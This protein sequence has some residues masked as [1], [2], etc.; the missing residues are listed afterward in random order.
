MTRLKRVDTQNEA[1][2]ARYFGEVCATQDMRIGV[3]NFMENGPRTPAKFV[4]A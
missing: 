2:E 1:L 3:S 4:N